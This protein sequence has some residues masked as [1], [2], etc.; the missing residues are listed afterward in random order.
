MMRTSVVWIAG[1]ALVSLSTATV[2]QHMGGPGGG[3]PRAMH[4]GGDGRE[5]VLMR[6]LRDPDVVEA[7]GITDEQLATLR[8][9]WLTIEKRGIALRA[10]LET[11]GLEQAS[12]L[13]EAQVD[14][15]AV[16]AAVEKT[17]A[18]RTELAKLKV[19]HLLTLKETLTEEQLKALRKIGHKH[20]REMGAGARR[21]PED[22]R[23]QDKARRRRPVDPDDTAPQ[24][25][26]EP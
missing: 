21:G 18:I 12:L 25:G 7:A 24:D 2:A 13:T 8:T 16:M 15:A 19:E 1:V 23:R 9:A 17:G 26:M 14:K 10:E 4:R 3:Q 11:A 5:A 22:G 20:A 6:M